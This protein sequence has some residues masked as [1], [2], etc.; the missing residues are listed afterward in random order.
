MRRWLLAAALACTGSVAAAAQIGAATTVRLNQ[1]GLTPDG[2]KRA[3]VPNESAAPL[4]WR[5]LDAGGDARAQGV[6]R[7]FG[8]D[9]YSG[10]HVHQVDF[11]GFRGEGEGFRLVVGEAR[12]RP[13]RIADGLYARLPYDALAY[14]YHNRSGTAI[15]PRYAGGERWARPAAHAP[16][17][18]T[19]FSGEDLNGNRW[20]GC[21][22]TLDVSRG[23]YDA[24]DHGKY[25]VNGGIAVWTLLNLYE[26]QR[27]RGGHDLF[28]DGTA[29]LPEAGN[30]VS[31]IL[32]EARWEIEFLLA[33]Q[34]PQG[35]RMR[36][37]VGV[38][39][40]GR[41]L[42]FTEIDASGMAHHKV[43]DEKWTGLPL[44]PD[45]DR[46][47]RFLYPPSTGATLNLAAT[48]A[49]C[50]RIWRTIDSDFSAR[51]LAAAEEAWAAA[52]RNPEVYAVGNFDGSGGYGDSDF[53]DEFYWAAAE[54]F[55][56][57]G[58]DSYAQALRASPHFSGPIAV[59]AWP[60]T[61]TLGTISLALVPSGLP[62]AE[63][64]AQRRRLIE[65]A[66]GFLAEAGRVGYHIPFAP[67]GYAWGSNSDILNRAM[68]LG[69]ARDWT[70]SERFRAGMLDAMDYLL[71][72][73]PLD[74]SFVSGYGARPMENP[75][76]R[77]W[78]HSM[79]P[80]FPPPPPGALSGGPNNTMM[81]DD[82]ARPMRGT[83][84]PQTCWADD[85]RAFSLNEVAVN[86]NA[87]LVWVAAYLAE[88]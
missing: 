57:T 83:C 56:T 31:D 86:W 46:E 59:H 50:A 85:I 66:E 28:S 42:A 14:F 88:R 54:L 32:D 84:A 87:P 21:G 43:A 20:P 4:R 25:V 55:V 58:R 35:T 6:T 77:F 70:G 65:A 23:W 64:D 74:R 8:R 61:A 17:R 49:Q 78:A 41:N 44:R 37:P 9:S 39:S 1:L 48:A 7:V 38:A 62:R 51:C 81:S 11:S 5:L 73:N 15:E 63:R 27:E 2:P 34:V 12:S 13:F 18:A 72:R 36:L 19:C 24:G 40:P 53:G 69:L 45:Q 26:R 80:A 22:Y 3:I 67:E 10:E 33:M 79:D 60:R 68:I 82:V 75:H 30:G 71:G 76:H 52:R 16:E 29:S 47:R